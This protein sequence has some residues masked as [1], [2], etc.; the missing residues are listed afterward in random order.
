MEWK[1]MGAALG[2]SKDYSLKQYL[3]FADK[4]Q[5]KAKVS[6]IFFFKCLCTFQFVVCLIVLHHLLLQL[7]LDIKWLRFCINVRWLCYM[8]YSKLNYYIVAIKVVQCDRHSWRNFSSNWWNI[9]GKI[10]RNRWVVSSLQVLD[11]DMSSFIISVT[12]A[13]MFNIMHVLDWCEIYNT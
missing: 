8:S 12:A 11:I 1:A 5:A 4:L 6:D 9:L 7:D 10:V 3:L 13:V 2:H